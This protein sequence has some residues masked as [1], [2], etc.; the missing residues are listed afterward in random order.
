MGNWKVVFY[1]VIYVALLI[2][3]AMN[4]DNY[5][6]PRHIAGFGAGILIS[7]IYTAIKGE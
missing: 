7:N 4:L 3:S 6:N 1:N 2:V 5:F